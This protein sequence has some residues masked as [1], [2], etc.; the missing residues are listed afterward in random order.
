MAN[1]NIYLIVNYLIIVMFLVF[2]IFNE[3]NKKKEVL[4]YIQLQHLLTETIIL[5]RLYVE[6][7]MH[8]ITVLHDVFLTFHAHLSGFFYRSFR[9]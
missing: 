7:E 5:I 2:H 1:I 8:D 3:D 4:Q 9:T 6:T